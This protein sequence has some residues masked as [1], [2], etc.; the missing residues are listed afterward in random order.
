MATVPHIFNGEHFVPLISDVPMRDNKDKNEKDVPVRDNEKNEENDNKRMKWS[1][2]C[3][4][5]LSVVGYCVGLGNLWR[6]PYLVNRN[7][8]G[9]AVCSLAYFDLLPQPLRLPPQPILPS[10]WPPSPHHS[11]LLSSSF[12]LSIIVII[13]T[14]T[15]TTATTTTATT[16]TKRTFFPLSYYYGY[17]F[18][19]HITT[20]TTITTTITTKRTF[21]SQSRLCKFVTEYFY[22]V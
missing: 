2:K 14:I 21:L 5:L 4:Y 19:H 20:T 3:E 22:I 9:K 10:R 6:F 1:S 8:G 11:L 12:C 16:T 18:Y 13:S 7:G 17:Y 15:T